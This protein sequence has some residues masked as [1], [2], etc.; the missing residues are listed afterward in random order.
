V[1]VFEIQSPGQDEQE[2]LDKLERI[3]EAL[4]KKNRGD[5]RVIPRAK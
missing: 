3:L 4:P 2:L 1:D 5:F